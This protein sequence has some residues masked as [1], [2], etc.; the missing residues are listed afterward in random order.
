MNETPLQVSP[1]SV[2]GQQWHVGEPFPMA[3]ECRSPGIGFAAI[4]AWI[5]ANREEFCDQ[6]H[7]HGAVL[8]RG[9]PLTTADDFDRFVAAFGFENFP[10]EDSLSN[11]V[12]VNRTP[13]VFTANE[14]PPTVEIFL[15]HEMAQ[16]P[17]YPSRLFFFCEQPA[18]QGGAT[19]LCRSDLLWSRL[20]ERCP[21]FTR[22]CVE[23]GL[24][25]SNVMPSSNDPNSG[26]GRS[27]QSTLRATNREEAE[28]RLK[29]L[30]YHWEWLDDGCLRVTTPVLPAVY[31]LAP[32]RS[33]FFNQLIAAYCG[34]KD[35]RNDPAKSITFG[36]GTP[37][38]GSAV[39]VAI[40]LAD[41]LTFDIPWKQGDVALVDNLVAMHGRRTFSGTRKV[42]ASLACPNT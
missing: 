17:F 19:P 5:G 20:V 8:F 4:E 18:E 14:A 31:K 12:R 21:E 36:D 41:E 32:G 9:F 22:D 24:N 15:H 3:W 11:A 16:T 2:P 26:M 38:D 42:L 10:Y 30:A 35:A 23:K 1:L 29:S 40:A 37:L 25:Y 6:A 34:W 27:W 13:R 7:R 28:Q 39:R 33:S